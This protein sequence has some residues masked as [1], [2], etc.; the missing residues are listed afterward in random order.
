MKRRVQLTF[1]SAYA[2]SQQLPRC[3]PRCLDTEFSH[4]SG[5]VRYFIERG[6]TF[7]KSILFRFVP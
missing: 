3:Y 5:C 6:V 2:I 4:I 7:S 1:L